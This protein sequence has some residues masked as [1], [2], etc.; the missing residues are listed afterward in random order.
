[1]GAGRGG[2]GG[3]LFS[4]GETTAKILKNNIDVRFADVAGCEEAKLEIMEFVNFLK[5][6]KQY[7]D[8]GAK[9]PKV[10]ISEMWVFDKFFCLDFVQF[11]NHNRG[12]K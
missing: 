11:T 1:M 2:R 3:G 6:P 12:W 10:L 4:V 9:I 8:L 5:N 7:Q